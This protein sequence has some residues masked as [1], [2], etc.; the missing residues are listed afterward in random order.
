MGSDR[1][2]QQTTYNITH[3]HSHQTSPPFVVSTLA[4]P[5]AV[6]KG[7]RSYSHVQNWCKARD[8]VL[9]MGVPRSAGRRLG[10]SPRPLDRFGLQVCPSSRVRS[11]S[12]APRDQVPGGELGREGGHG[13]REGGVARADP[14][15]PPVPEGTAATPSP[16]GTDASTSAAPPGAIISAATAAATAA[17][18]NLRVGMATSGSAGVRARAISRSRTSLIS[19]LAPRSVPHQGPRSHSSCEAA[20]SCEVRRVAPLT[21]AVVSAGEA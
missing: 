7:R 10:D 8:R 4:D 13:D 11:Q 2:D 3:S 1:Q 19:T 18:A 14:P 9:A 21:R 16:C 12:E 5:R 6:G 17:P 15:C 20:G